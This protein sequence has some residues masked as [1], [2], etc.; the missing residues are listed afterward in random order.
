MGLVRLIDRKVLDLGFDALEKNPTLRLSINL[1]G[2]T[3][4]DPVWL[5]QLSERLSGRRHVAERLTLEIT[6]TVALDDIDESSRFVR[7]LAA[8]GCRVAL[9][10]FGAGFTSFR[11]L[12][13]L[14]VHMVK[15]DGSFVRDLLHNPDNQVFVR[16]LVGLAK[17]IDLVA[18]AEWVETEAEA[19]FLLSNGV[20]YLQGFLFGRPEIGLPDLA[21]VPLQELAHSA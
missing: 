17:G 13:A 7:T 2:L 18:V 19:E 8:L 21:P 20:D 11:H 1:S 4:V 10:D 16:T 6:E 3:A 9:D 15:I 5:A 14:K 12:R